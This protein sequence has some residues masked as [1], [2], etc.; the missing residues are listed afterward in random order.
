MENKDDT[1]KIIWLI[2]FLFT[3]GALFVNKLAPL[4]LAWWQDILYLILVY[5]LWPLILGA[6]FMKR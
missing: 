4:D 2:G 6:M 1:F 3:L 5:V